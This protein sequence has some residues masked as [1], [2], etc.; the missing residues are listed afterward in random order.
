[1]GYNGSRFRTL[2]DAHPIWAVMADDH[3]RL[4]ANNGTETNSLFSY[5]VKTENRKGVS[6]FPLLVSAFFHIILLKL[7][8]FERK[9]LES[10]HENPMFICVNQFSDLCVSP[11]Y[12]E[13]VDSQLSITF[14]MTSCLPSDCR[15]PVVTAIT[16]AADVTILWPSYR[17]RS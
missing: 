14:S 16:S 8:I 3:F 9:L 4:M 17:R 7:N 2:Y 5:M 15:L 10:A 13:R 11:V 12:V 1:M 6:Y